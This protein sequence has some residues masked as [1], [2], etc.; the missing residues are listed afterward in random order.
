MAKIKEPKSFE[1]QIEILKQRGM[2]IENEEFAKF[3]LSNVNYYRLTAY[4]LNFKTDKDKYIEG[5]TFDLNI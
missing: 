1:E 3:V 4:L 5:A 2:A